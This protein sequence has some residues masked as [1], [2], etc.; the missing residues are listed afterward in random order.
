MNVRL[1][2][3]LCLL[4]SLLLAGTALAGP[5]TPLLWKA[6]RGDATVYLLGSMHILLATDYPL[7]QDVDKAYRDAKQ[8]L[9][10]MPP[11]EMSPLSVLGPTATLGMYQD[12]SQSLQKDLDPQT[13]QRLQAYAHANGMSDFMLSRMRPWLA[14]LTILALEMKKL[15]Y[16][17]N[18][19]LDK[20]FM[21]Q[22]QADHK[23]TG[24]FETAEQQLRIIAST[25]LAE[26]VRDLR[27][28]LDD[29]PKFGNK[30]SQMHATWRNGDADGLYREEAKEYKDQPETMQRLIVS[31]NRAWV[32]QLD[33]MVAA[34]H[35]KTLVIVG[36]LHLLGPDGLVELLR[37]DGYRVERV[38][39]GCVGLR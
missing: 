18:L 23:Q 32:P 31:R 35:G 34:V 16:D 19:G 4:L 14:S 6:T 1:R 33:R 13:W 36:A 12:P 30:M 11:D 26:Q 17:P 29:L 7:S 38:C 27:Q 21:D 28:M 22:A 20:H 8:V 10:E 3:A 24:G 39:T 5:P 15:S 2:I 9:F 25:P 37:K